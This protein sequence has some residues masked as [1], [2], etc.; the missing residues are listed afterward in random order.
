MLRKGVRIGAKGIVIIGLL[1]LCLEQ[2]FDAMATNAV[3]DFGVG[4]FRQDTRKT[5][6]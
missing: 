4:R 2:A 5:D 3:E 1:E 6:P